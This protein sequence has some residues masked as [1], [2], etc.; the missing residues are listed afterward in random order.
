MM[1]L[2]KFFDVTKLTD[3]QNIDCQW[4]RLIKSMTSDLSPHSKSTAYISALVNKLFEC[5]WWQTVSSVLTAHIWLK[6]MTP[7][8]IPKMTAS[9]MSSANRMI[10][11]AGEVKP[12]I[13]QIMSPKQQSEIHGAQKPQKLMYTSLWK[14]YSLNKDVSPLLKFCSI[15]VFS[16]VCC[17]SV[18]KAINSHS[19]DDGLCLEVSKGIR[20]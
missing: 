9:S 17:Q 1:H 16:P 5:K 20:V 12:A 2:C 7:V 10:E 4:V 15:T 18:V 8:K 14:K 13:V 19:G 11:A 3:R 6:N